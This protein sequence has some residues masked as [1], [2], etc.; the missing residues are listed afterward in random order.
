MHISLYRSLSDSLICSRYKFNL[1]VKICEPIQ[2]QCKTWRCQLNVSKSK[3]I[4]SLHNKHNP[5]S[6]KWMCWNSRRRKYYEYTWGCEWWGCFVSKWMA[7]GGGAKMWSDLSKPCELWWL[8][9]FFATFQKF[10]NI[11]NSS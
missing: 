6:P 5:H 4:Q 3:F 9:V 11:I 8:L 10:L 2:V 7:W 1:K